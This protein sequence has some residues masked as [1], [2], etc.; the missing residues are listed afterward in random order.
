MSKLW[1]PAG[2]IGC[3]A[4][5]IFA[6][7]GTRYTIPSLPRGWEIKT[8]DPCGV[9][10]LRKRSQT[11]ALIS[12]RVENDHWDSVWVHLSVS[13]P[14]RIPDWDELAELKK[15]LMPDLKAIQVFPTEAEWVSIHPNVLHLWARLDGQD[16]IPDFR[17]EVDG[18]MMI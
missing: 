9:A 12:I 7:D 8:A 18:I 2:S 6:E 17:R 16:G 15:L 14:D 13:R 10:Y 3:P 11:L 5:A 4:V 1:T